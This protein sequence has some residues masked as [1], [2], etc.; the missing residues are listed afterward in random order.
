V[1]DLVPAGTLPD[2][3]GPARL[4]LSPIVNVHI[5]YDRAVT[6]LRF[7][8]AVDSPVQ[9][10]FDRTLAAGLERG[11]YL[12]VSLSG[13]TDIVDQTVDWFRRTFLPA[14]S[15]LFPQ[16]RDA[17]V[18]RFLVTRERGATFRQTPG[19]AALRPGPVTGIPRLFLAGAWTDTGWP[20]TMEGA[21]RSGV[22]AAR[23][24][25]VALGRTERLP[26]EVAA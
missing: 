14:L 15:D 3:T 26:A 21:V 9:W 11:Q 22:T 16:A 6:S 25:L 13:A 10:V 18:E 19:T 7:A 5:V 24:A 23:H 20:A 1:G 8:A 2:P 12:A 4:G 17:S